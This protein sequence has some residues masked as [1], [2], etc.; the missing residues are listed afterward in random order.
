MNYSSK[1]LEEAIEA[2]ASLPSIGKKSALRMVLHL[3][4]D[5]NLKKEK[6]IQALH[7]VIN[8]LNVCSVC[9]SY[10]DTP[11]CNICSDQSRKNDQICVVESIKDVIAIE[12]TQSYSG[13]YHVLG[14]VISPLEGVGPEDIRVM[15]LVQRVK[16][17]GPDELI[18]ALSPTI[19]GETTI[20]YISKLLED[21][22]VEISTIARGVAFGGEIS[23][24]DE[25]TLGRSISSRQPYS[26]KAAF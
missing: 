25:I 26:Q 16:D 4:Q 18:M 6:I 19:D 5:Q 10:A 24:A 11:V 1:I 20:F 2:F 12:E 17:Q 3:A 14:G 13:L 15:E 8:D 9:Y 7:R 23:Y 22:A 21:E